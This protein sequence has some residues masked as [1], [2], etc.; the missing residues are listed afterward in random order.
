MIIGRRSAASDAS[1][2]IGRVYD[3]AQNVSCFSLI[4]SLPNGSD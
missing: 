2:E 1:S 3:L 4:E